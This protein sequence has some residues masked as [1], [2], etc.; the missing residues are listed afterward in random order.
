[1]VEQ[2]VK[3]QYNSQTSH[4]HACVC[5]FRLL[6]AADNKLTVAPLPP[7]IRAKFALWY[8]AAQPRPSSACPELARSCGNTSASSYQ[9]HRQLSFGGSCT[10]CQHV[11]IKLGTITV[12]AIHTCVPG[13]LASELHRHQP[14]RALRSGA[15]T[16]LHQPHASS[17]FHRHFFAVSAPA[18]WNN[19]PAAVRDFVSLDTFKAAFKTHFNRA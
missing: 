4:I 16:I 11:E 6:A 17:D 1:M 2:N 13:Y 15:S 8:V 10:G 9:C 7:I 12:R 14:S 19:I 18:V 3:S 5:C